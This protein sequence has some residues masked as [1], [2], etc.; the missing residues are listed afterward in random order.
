MNSM[1]PKLFERGKIGRLEIENRIIKAPT[2]YCICN[3]DGSVTDRLVRIY[4]ELARGGSGLVTVEAASTAKGFIGIPVLC[5]GGIEYIPGL[6]MLAQT[7]HDN[8]AKASLQLAPSE[9]G[10]PPKVPSRIATEEQEMA[11]WYE[12]TGSAPIPEEFT[13]E[14]IREV[15]ASTGNAAKLAQLAG[16]DMVEVHGGHGALPHQF[17][18]PARNIRNDL[19]GGSLKNRM[20]FMVELARDIKKKTGADFPLSMRLSAID[21]EPDGVV[22]EETLELVKVLEQVG[23][24]VIH[25]SGGSHARLIHLT[26]PMSIPAGYHV[27][28]AEAVKKVVHI[29]VIA[30]GSITTPQLAEEILESGKA[31]FVS[32]ARTLFADPYWPQK[33]R[34]GRPE[35]IAPCIRCNDGCQ[36]RTNLHF[37]SL[38]C[39]VN[40]ALGWEDR[41]AITPAEHR[42]DVA[43]VGGGPAG[44]EAARVC[45]LRGHK[46]TLYEKRKL[47]GALIEASVPEFKA[48]IRRLISYYATQVKKLKVKVIREE[49]TVNTIK[50]GN[51]D[52]VIVAVGAA[53]RKPDVPG[54]KKPIVTDVLAVLSGKAK[55]GQQVHIVGG[56]IIGVEVGIFLA[57]QGKEVIF[58]TRGDEL[59]SGVLSAERI[60]YQER[61]AGLPV[62]IYTGKRL[63]SVLDRGAIVV[64]KNGDRQEI[65]ADSIV[66]ATGFIP[67]T[68]IKEKLEKE[69]SLEIYAIGD[70]VEPRMIY[71][72][73]H[74][75]YLTARKI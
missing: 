63:E 35:D 44:M 67:Q 65:S 12:I 1:F 22:L 46:V 71:D 25:V 18:S 62:T 40:V 20:R 55:V 52:A 59:M 29:P 68:A 60:A 34:Q 54:I 13:V 26:S 49:A 37:Q 9:G 45:A 75:G 47:G 27:A 6:S 33:A 4:E 21:Y 72:A 10:F 43:V 69:T 57:E 15:I 19:Y 3:P 58:T 74:E 24:D 7:I 23:V 17:F 16:F 32:F 56:G 64:D 53:L 2:M 70:C 38:R 14:E 48:D 5:A 42:K 39:T 61:L 8:G 28:S 31:D 50:D 11:H 73:I 66:L 41:L 30:S 51:F 36:D